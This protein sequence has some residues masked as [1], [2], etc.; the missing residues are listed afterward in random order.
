MV[1]LILLVQIVIQLFYY[2]TWQTLELYGRVTI[3]KI[4]NAALPEDTHLAVRWMIIMVVAAT[5][6]PAKKQLTRQA[7]IPTCCKEDS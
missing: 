6:A 5:A 1:H 7:R 3:L 4:N 2:Y